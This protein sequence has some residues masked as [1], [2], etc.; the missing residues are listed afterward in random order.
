MEEPL[1][2]R[3]GISTSSAV[4]E[5]RSHRS[6]K[7][8]PTPIPPSIS[9]HT[10]FSSEEQRV[11][12]N[13]L[14]SSRSIIDPKFVD[15]AFFDDEVFD[16]FQA[17]Q[18]SG[19][20]Q[21]ISMK[22]SFYPELVKAFY[23]NL[24]I[25]EDSL[26]SKVYGIKMV[27]DQSLF[28]ELTK[29]SSDGV[30]F[31]GTV[32]DEWK[33]DF[34]VFDARRMVCTNQADMTGRLLASSLAFECHIMHYLIVRILLPRSSNLAQVYE[35]DLIIMWVFLTGRQIDWAH[36]LRY[37]MHK[38][39]RSNAPLPYPHLITLFLQHFNV[40]LDSEPFVKGKRSF[41]I[42]ANV[43]SSFRYRKERD[44]SWMKK[45]APVQ[46]AED[47]SPSPHSQR[48]DSSSLMYNILDR[49]DGLH[50][51]VDEHFDSLDSRIDA[52]DARFARMDTCIT[53]LEEDVSFVH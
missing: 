24:E 18:N 44:G 17:F 47:R 49:L 26:I 8:Q 16:C 30:P 22:L 23:S 6:S 35:E 5:T 31:E 53:K 34:S 14:F 27:I 41:S 45:D 48:D 4:I 11:W 32:D 21:F 28:F 3:K 50:T 19:L 9:S 13:S 42:G 7:V 12:Y 33:F 38:T 39:L 52:M 20:I 46:A 1:K 51:F 36:L 2:K 40:P 29:L 25:Q 15:L 43:V 10:L 37:H